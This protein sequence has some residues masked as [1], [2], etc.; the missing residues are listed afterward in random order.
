MQGPHMKRWHEEFPRTY[1]EWRKHYLSHVE[2]NISY[3]RD[4]GRDPY[5]I[6]CPCEQQKGFFRKRDAWDCGHTQCRLCHSYKFPK[7][8]TT[9]HERRSELKFNEGIQESLVP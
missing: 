2:D 9:L 1:R 8:V 7:R 6:D 4:P 3:T 5:Q